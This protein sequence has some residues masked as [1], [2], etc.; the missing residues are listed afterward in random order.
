MPTIIDQLQQR[1]RQTE[2]NIQALADRKQYILKRQGTVDTIDRIHKE[3]AVVELQLNQ[4]KIHLKTLKEQREDTVKQICFTLQEGINSYLIEGEASIEIDEGKV[5]ICW[6]LADKLHP[7]KLH[8]MESLSGG[9]KVEF[10]NALSQVLFKGR[11]K[12]IHI[13]LAELWDDTIALLECQAK[14]EGVQ[15]IACTQRKIAKED[16]SDWEVITL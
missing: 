5:S 12:L 1:I 2:A 3:K 7:I 11:H 16:L 9:E 10:Y 8:P 4:I 14:Q 6:L 15:V 13:E